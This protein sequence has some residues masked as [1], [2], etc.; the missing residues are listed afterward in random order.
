MLPDSEDAGVWGVV[1]IPEDGSTLGLPEEVA[2]DCDS[3]LPE[4][5]IKE[6]SEF[7]RLSSLPMRLEAPREA[8][9]RG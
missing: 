7:S 5:L 2:V 8:V 6:M 1:T 9:A 3:A 4:S